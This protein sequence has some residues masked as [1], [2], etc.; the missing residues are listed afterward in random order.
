MTDSKGSHATRRSAVVAFSP[1]DVVWAGVTEEGRQTS[2]WTIDGAPVPFV[3]FAEDWEPATE[4]PIYRDLYLHSRRL[5]PQAVE[6]AAIPVERITTL[7]QVVGGHDLVWPADLH[8]EAIARR[9]AEHGLT[10]TTVVDRE[11]GHR[12]ILPGEPVVNAG[13]SMQRGG[14]ESANRRLGSAAW[15]EIQAL[16]KP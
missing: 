4:P 6:V 9:R 14:N 13:A 5:D 10:T 3:P 7:I 2:H 15:T 11:A 16:L 12:A 1:T 8:A